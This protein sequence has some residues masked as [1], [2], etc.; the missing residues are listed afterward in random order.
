MQNHNNTL[1]IQWQQYENPQ[2]L[3]AT[4]QSLLQAAKD[5]AEKAYA[6]YSNFYVGAAVLLASGEILSG[7]NFENAAYPMCLCAERSA[8]ANAISTFPEG[9][10]RTMA[11]TV[12][13][14]K[15]V[16][17]T[18]AAPCG[19]CRQVMVEVEYR[20]QSDMQVILQGERGPVYV[21]P[22]AKAL[23]PFHFDGSFL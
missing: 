1:Q 19:A 11:I 17:Q 10:V 8:L 14:P 13:N 9:I 20:Q 15:Q 12:R 22:S 6:P 4:E 2:A 5:A 7:S 3:P 21:L 18:P 23:L 16:I